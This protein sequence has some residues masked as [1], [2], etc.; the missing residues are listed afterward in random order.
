MEINFYSTSRGTCHVKKFITDLNPKTVK[1]ITRQLDLLEK[2]GVNFLTK[3]GTMKKLQG[4]DI[5][6]LIIDFN[7]VCY[8]I[9]CVIRN[10]TCWLMHMFKKKSN[11]TPFKEVST[12]LS[13][14]KDLDMQL[15]L[16]LN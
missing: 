13:R 2:Y 3:S 16:A 4:Y 14:I 15:N 5:Y 7:N 8:R 9:F 1:K 6:E 12:T 10:T 11:A